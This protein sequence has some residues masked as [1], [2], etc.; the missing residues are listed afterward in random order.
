TPTP[1]PALDPALAAEFRV[2]LNGTNTEPAHTLGFTG[3]GYMIGVVDSGVN[4]N[5]VTLH[6][7]VIHNNVYVDYQ[8]P[9]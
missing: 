5:H 1:L 3:K 2:H 4:R 9:A 7:Q 6:D 8:D